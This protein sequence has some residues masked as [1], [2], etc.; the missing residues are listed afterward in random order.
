MK[1]QRDIAGKI[2]KKRREV[3]KIID[4]GMSVEAAVR[5]IGGDVFKTA[6][7][8]GFLFSGTDEAFVPRVCQAL[9]AR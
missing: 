5:Q 8:S 2:I 9:I 4:R 3:A 1:C 6:L 7:L